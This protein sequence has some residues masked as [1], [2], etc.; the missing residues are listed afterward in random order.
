M[1]FL[2]A[3][4]LGVTFVTASRPAPLHAQTPTP[5]PAVDSLRQ[6]LEDLEAT[7]QALKEQL[8]A[9]A[10]TAVRTRSRMGMEF[11]GRVLV[12][13]L[14]TSAATNNGDLPLFVSPLL[15]TLPPL[16]GERPGGTTLSMR[17]SMF[18]LAVTASDILG[19][20]FVGDV[21][22]DF[23]GGQMT[24]SGGRHF[25]LVRLRTARAALM[26]DRVTLMAGQ[27][28][29]LITDLDPVSLATIGTPGFANA[30]NL[31]LW[32]P[33]LRASYETPGAVRFGVQAA[34]LAPVVE[35]TT[36]AF[37]AGFDA[38]ERSRWPSLQARLSAKWGEDE[39]SGEI[40]VG[41]HSG[42]VLKLGDAVELKSQALAVSALVPFGR[43]LELRGEFFDGQLLS[44]LGGGGIGQGTNNNGD[45]LPTTGGW[46]QLNL[47]PSMRWMIGVGYGV[48]APERDQVPSVTGRLRNEA[49]ALHAQWTPAGPIIVGLEWRKLATTYA[50]GVRNADHINL[51]LGFTF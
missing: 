47:K 39:R 30:G 16:P 36:G 6:R 11:H 15:P 49:Q 9:D 2:T 24:S 21:D 27:D 18:G 42:R 14:H 37:N 34:I 26:W 35:R 38:A 44:G 45:A 17:Q 29:P 50:T 5:E 41:V 19:G 12:H 8:S 3:V 33:Q 31:W 25:P 51:A 23:F 4:L 22:V 20:T 1:R 7:V 28:Q 46:A 10:S 13:A 32:L 48:D 40:G 43:I